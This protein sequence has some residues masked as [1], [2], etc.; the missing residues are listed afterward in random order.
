M[1]TNSIQTLTQFNQPAILKAI[2][3]RRIAKFFNGFTEE[4]AGGALL[5]TINSEPST[6]FVALAAL[7][8]S[9]DRLPNPLLSALLAIERVAAPE[10]SDRL[11]AKSAESKG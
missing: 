8:A 5:S 1:K 2:D 10:N 6:D 3:Q 9:P 11:D 4:L 7:L